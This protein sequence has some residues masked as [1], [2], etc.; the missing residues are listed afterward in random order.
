MERAAAESRQ[1]DRKRIIQPLH[2]S[3]ADAFQ[4]MF[5]VIQPGSYIRPH[6]HLHPPKAESIVV[7]HGALC[8]VVFDERGEIE[9]HFDL[10]ADG[11]RIGVDIEPGVMHTFFA[12]E[13]DT[14]VFEAK[15]GPYS[16]MTDKD[17]AP[18]APEE[19]DSRAT[20]YLADLHA[21]TSH[22]AALPA[23]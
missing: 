11:E 2:K 7:L 17:F 13:P 19:T 6:R 5:N 4:R 3:H 14:V 10:A 9:R 20:S 22:S 23:T 12:L 18:W 8:F 21:A 16:A 1:S 15:P